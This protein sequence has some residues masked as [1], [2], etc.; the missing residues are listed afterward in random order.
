MSGVGLQNMG[1]GG[2]YGGSPLMVYDHTTAA[3]HA[4]PSAVLSPLKNF[5][6]GFQSMYV[7]CRCPPPPPHT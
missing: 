6:V 4:M 3:P 7:L 5:K 1:A 2:L